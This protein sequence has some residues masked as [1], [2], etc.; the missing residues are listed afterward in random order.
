MAE[1]R[2]IQDLKEEFLTIKSVTPWTNVEVNAVYHIPPLINLDRR[3]IM[4]LSKK[5]NNATYRRIGDTQQIERTL[6]KD[7]VFAR[8]IV[9]RKKF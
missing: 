9:K 7:S 5:D 8:F 3:D 4:I 1:K 6:H 2:S